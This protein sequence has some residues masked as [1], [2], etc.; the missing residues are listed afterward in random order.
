MLEKKVVIDSINTKE[1][2]YI[3]VCQKTNVLE[4]D[5]E[6]SKTYHR[7]VIFPGQ[8]VKDQDVKVQNIA[9][10]V[11]TQE[12]IDAYVASLKNKNI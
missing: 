12:V 3:E 4:D 1:N 7:W 11:H 10:V 8:D 6:I 2:G 9:K 5:K